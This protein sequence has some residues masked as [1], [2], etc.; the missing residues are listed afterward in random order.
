MYINCLKKITA[1][2]SEEEAGIVRRR[3]FNRAYYSEWIRITYEKN[4]II[5]I[6][7]KMAK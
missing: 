2:I 7:I 5:I 3:A 4:I 6:T 1:I